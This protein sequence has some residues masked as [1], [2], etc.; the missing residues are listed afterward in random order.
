MI[1]TVNEYSADVLRYWAGTGRLGTDIIFS[2]ETLLRGKK[3]I[4]KKANLEI[5]L[6]TEELLGDQYLLEIKYGTEKI[7]KMIETPL[8]FI[9]VVNNDGTATIKGYTG[10]SR[11]IIIPSEIQGAAGL[12]A[13]IAETLK[14]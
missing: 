9:Y 4:N 3:L 14:K 5:L 7:T 8:D 10:S 13:G 1:D 2:D 12:A 11:E 6:D